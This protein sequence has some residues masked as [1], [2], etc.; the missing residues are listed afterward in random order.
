MSHIEGRRILMVAP[1]PFFRPRGTPF[2]VLHRIRALLAAGHRVDLV[3]YPFGEDV[4]LPG[5]EIHRVA[6][7]PMVRDVRIGPSIAKVLLDIALYFATARQLKRQS[8][9][10][11]HSH[12]EAAFFAMTLA[13]KH[14]VRH[15]YDMHSS[16]PN[17]LR[18]FGFYK[19]VG[20]RRVFESSERR[21]LST[22]D[23]V[24][25]ISSALSE[26]A[27]R[28]CGA[29]PH[30]LIEN[31]GDDASVFQVVPENPRSDLGIGEDRLILYT[32][33]LEAYQ[34]LDMLLEAHA[35]LLRS[36]GDIHLAIVGGQPAQ[37][38]NYS[39]LANELGIAHA[40]TFVGTVHPSRIPAFLEAADMII[41]P[42]ARGTY[43]PLKLYGYLRSG[44]PLV[45]TDLAAHTQVLDSS[46]A[47]LVPPTVEGIVEGIRRVL[48]DRDYAER[49]AA[50]AAARAE[51][52]YSDA[53]YL[54]EVSDFYSLVLN[55]D[56]PDTP[57]PSG[58]PTGVSC[59]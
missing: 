13:K 26:I 11:L 9:D 52:R 47:H 56:R 22:C 8:Y 42:R 1:Q 43:T 21:V 39:R 3:T 58:A 44:R 50:A 41:S 55:A 25:T 35:R 19:F 28:H 27:E 4:D 40:V 45:A 36:T 18:N 5:L 30:R 29:T 6:R 14:G 38:D 20:F 7:P 24:I 54:R 32:G 10:V 34:G 57:S 12:E 33:T 37:V 17:Q 49:L 16:L 31:S 23:G 15:V 53:A 46:I 2:S 51:E 59:H 48:G